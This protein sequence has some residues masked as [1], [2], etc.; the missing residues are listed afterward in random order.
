MEPYGSWFERQDLRAMYAYYRDLL[1]LLDWQRPGER[2]L[3]KSPAHLWALDVLVEMFPD[4]CIIWTH[5]NP[6]QI[7][8][9]YCSMMA[10]LMGIR[11]SADPQELGPRVLEH[12]AL[13]LE[14]GLAARDRSDPSR[15]IDVDYR[16]LV[17]NPMA[18]VRRI[19]G[20]FGLRLDDGTT[21]AM[22]RHVA[23][24]PQAKH[25]AH[26]YALEQFGLTPEMVRTRLADYVTRFALPTDA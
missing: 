1:K 24:E 25:G 14:R 16:Q 20:A 8:P 22:E 23:A 7:I 13:S 6:L 15:F 3:L 5:R 17:A 21:A 12:L 9:S 11:E 26:R 4:V 10:A 19:Y 2:W 18:T